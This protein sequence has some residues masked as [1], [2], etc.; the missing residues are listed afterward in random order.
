MP[1]LMLSWEWMSIYALRNHLYAF[2]LA[3]PG[4]ILKLLKWDTNFMIVNS[5]YIMQCIA[6]TFG[7][8]YFYRLAE[9]L[10]GK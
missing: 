4:F 6:W 8:F 5:M 3:L 9:V 10:G 1:E 7:D 2:W